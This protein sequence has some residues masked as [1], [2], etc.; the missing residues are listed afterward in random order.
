MLYY[1]IF[2]EVGR[3]FTSCISYDY[4]KH[5][6]YIYIYIYIMQYEDATPS[7]QSTNTSERI[8]VLTALGQQF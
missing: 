7:Q 5:I 8:T 4:M 6:A 2:T 1:Y 3:N